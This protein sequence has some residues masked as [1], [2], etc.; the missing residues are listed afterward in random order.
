MFFFLRDGRKIWTWIV[1]LA[2]RRAR[3]KIHDAADQ[4]W[5]TLAGYVRA[6]VLVAF[7]DAIGIGLGLVILGVPLALPLTAFVFLASF[8]PIIGALIS[9][10]VAVLVALVTVGL[11]K[12]I[13]VLAVVGISLHLLTGSGVWD[14]IASILIGLLLVGVAVSLG[15]TSKRNLIGEALPEAKREGL[16]RV[17]NDPMVKVAYSGEAGTLRPAGTPAR[18]DSEAFRVIQSAAARNYDTVTI[19]TSISAAI[20]P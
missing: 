15:S 5:W 4:A 2:P 1:G 19:P 11:V 8:I 20:A 14:G 3:T 10:V 7:V 9:G 6:T 17:I 16:T 13:I 12:A 18:L